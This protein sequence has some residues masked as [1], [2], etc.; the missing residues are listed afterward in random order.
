MVEADFHLNYE[1]VS[2]ISSGQNLSLESIQI[3]FIAL[4]D[5]F[6]YSQVWLMFL[7]KLHNCDLNQK[8]FWYL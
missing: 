3:F 1:K 4:F 2:T 8:P 6:F 5:F 7:R